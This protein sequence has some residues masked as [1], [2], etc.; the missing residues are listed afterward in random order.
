MA[1]SRIVFVWMGRLRDIW[2]QIDLMLDAT[3]S[4]KAHYRMSPTKHKEWH[5]KVE[6]LLAKEYV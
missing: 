5:I 1:D 3:L 2:H 4:N 6:E